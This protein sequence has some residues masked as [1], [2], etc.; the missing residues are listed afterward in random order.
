VEEEFEKEEDEQQQILL[1]LQGSA[2]YEPQSAPSDGVLPHWGPRQGRNTNVHPF[3][4][5]AKKCEKK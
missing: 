3:V 4:G 1:L 5:P 2:R